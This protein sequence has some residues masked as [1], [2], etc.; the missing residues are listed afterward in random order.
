MSD[1]HTQAIT[2]GTCAEQSTH[3]FRSVGHG[4]GSKR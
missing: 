2:S 4:C 1:V 3:A